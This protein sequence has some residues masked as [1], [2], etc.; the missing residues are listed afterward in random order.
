MVGGLAI[1]CL[2]WEANL[3]HCESIARIVAGIFIAVTDRN[4]GLDLRQHGA[5]GNFAR[6]FSST[7]KTWERFLCAALRA[8]LAAARK[9]R[10]RA[11]YGTAKAVPLRK[12]ATQPRTAVPHK[13]CLS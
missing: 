13:L 8:C 6:G 5:S 1:C 12:I 7:Q 10:F 4:R 2:F 11:I 9:W 3:T